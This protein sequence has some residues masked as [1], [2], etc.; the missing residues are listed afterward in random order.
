[1]E[2]IKMSEEINKEQIIKEF[3]KEIRKKL[4]GWLKDNKKEL[5]DV[6]SELESHI[7]EKSEEIAAGQE[8]QIQHIQ[9]AVQAMGNPRDIASEYKKRGT[10][11]IWISKELFPNYLKVL[12]VVIG[13][14]VGVNIIS[15]T[16]DAVSNG[17]SKNLLTYV[18]GIFSSGLGAFL[19]V[20][21]I[22][23]ILS[24]EGYLPENFKKSKHKQRHVLESPEQPSKPSKRVQ[25]PLRRGGLLAG[26]IIT[27]LLGLAMIAK[28][29]EFIPLVE[30]IGIPLTQFIQIAGV[31]T[32][33]GG[34]I[35]LIQSMMDLTNYFA[36]RVLIALYTINDLVFLAFIS[37][38]VPAVLSV[39]AIEAMGVDSE[40]YSSIELGFTV[41]MWF[42]IVG[43]ILG[44]IT[45]IS[46]IITLQM[47]FEEYLR[48]QEM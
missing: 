30:D 38:L 6:L 22:F 21:I 37:R 8:V 25:P 14:I 41:V 12:A 36:Q 42:I 24:V 1:M 13:V 44:A 32:M 2:V 45:N 23:V 29:W 26:G 7:W 43:T 28:V 16:V 17:F 10:P 18:D 46:K 9:H 20:T 5:K 40:L 15:F 33:I 34:F 11:K 3:L 31:F 47:K 48:Y 4:P 39:P 27:L 35:N 19:V